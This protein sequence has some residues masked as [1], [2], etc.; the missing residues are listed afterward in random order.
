M[1]NRIDR[2]Q[3]YSEKRTRITAAPAGL[4]DSR[5]RRDSSGVAESPPECPGERYSGF[6]GRQY[7]SLSEMG[8]ISEVQDTTRVSSP[9]FKF[10]L[11]THEKIFHLCAA[12]KLRDID[13]RAGRLD[14]YTPIFMVDISFFVIWILLKDLFY[15]LYLISRNPFFLFHY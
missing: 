3:Q 14:L 1:H 8:D 9:S 12:F 2:V 5:R 13:H 11:K 10:F 6:L 4:G 15:E 7:D